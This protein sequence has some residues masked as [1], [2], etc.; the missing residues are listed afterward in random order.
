ML[1]HRTSERSRVRYEAGALLMDGLGG[2]QVAHLLGRYGDVQNQS[3]NDLMAEVVVTNSCPNLATLK[4]SLNLQLLP[5]PFRMFDA[6]I[7]VKALEA[8]HKERSRE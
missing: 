6:E 1:C 4:A 5:S 2:H 3:E 7:G 8:N